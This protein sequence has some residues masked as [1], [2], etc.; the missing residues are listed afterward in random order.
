L[1][2]VKLC[3][4]ICCLWLKGARGEPESHFAPWES[5]KIIFLSYTMDLILLSLMKVCSYVIL[6]ELLNLL[7]CKWKEN[8]E[9][10][11]MWSEQA[12]AIYVYSY[13]SF[14]LLRIFITL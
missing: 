4:F 10:C 13:A 6:S 1:L 2:W 12:G 11:S 5:T 9:Y 14:I 3:V 8:S 7:Q